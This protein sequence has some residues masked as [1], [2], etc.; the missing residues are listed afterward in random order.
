MATIT[1]PGIINMK[2]NKPLRIFETTLVDGGKG[3]DISL[4]AIIV[5]DS[6]AQSLVSYLSQAKN[7]IN[8]LKG[9][10]DTLIE[11]CESNYK[12]YQDS[13]VKMT[14]LIDDIEG[15]VTK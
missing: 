5:S 9:S 1:R 6:T 15:L 4:D 2:Y 11:S 3:P 12:S 10:S 13:L 7:T 14:R 8:S